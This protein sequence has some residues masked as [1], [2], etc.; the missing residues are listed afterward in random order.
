MM[1]RQKFQSLIEQEAGRLPLWLPAFLGLGVVLFFAQNAPVSYGVPL[2]LAGISAGAAW[3]L[4][5]S[6]WRWVWWLC[7]ML[8]LGFAA[9]AYRVQAVAEPM[10]SRAMN[11]VGI[12]GVI[13]EIAVQP[14]KRAKLVLEPTWIDDIA[15]PELPALVR[16]SVRSTDIPL[17]VGDVVK[18]RANLFPPGWPMFAGDYDFARYFY[19]ER[20]G[21]L[22]YVMGHV[23]LVQAAPAQADDWRAK[24]MQLRL[25]V[26]QRVRSVVT[27][28]E[29]AVTAAL[30][31]AEQSPI[32]D[33]TQEH[34]RASGLAH[35]L[36]ISGL[37]LT[38]V[39]GAAFLA[40]RLLCLLV[41]VLRRR[42]WSKKI[43]ALGAIMLS[44]FYLALA[45]FPVAAERS[46][47]MVAF[48]L[49]A[50]LFDRQVSPLR[51][52][53]FA[54][55]VIL[56]IWP[57]SIFSIS[58]ILSF[59]ATLAILALAEDIRRPVVEFL[60]MDGWWRKPLVYLAGVMATSFVAGMA[61]MPFVMHQ[62]QQINLYS[63]P[64]NMLTSPLVSF[65]I[66][67]GVMLSLLLMPL[68]F[69][70]PI[71][72]LTGQGVHYML[73]ASAWVR[74]WPHAILHALPMTTVGVVLC[75]VGGLWLCLWQTRMRWV[76]LSLVL[77]GAFSSLQQTLPDIY[78]AQDAKM[79]TVKDAS[80]GYV[81]LGGFDDHR[82][83]KDWLE[84]VGQKT[85][86]DA[87]NTPQN[88][89]HRWDCKDGGCLITLG[90][91]RVWLYRKKGEATCPEG[92]DGAILMR[93]NAPE[94]CTPK[95]FVLDE[96]TM[97]QQGGTWLN[98]EGKNWQIKDVRSTIG[99]WP[100]HNVQEQMP[101]RDTPPVAT[102]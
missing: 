8:W 47:I 27:G 44:F 5:Q 64:A 81:L 101:P 40:L 28:D 59:A 36:S 52:L 66:M 45:N 48:F 56:L 53:G 54:A 1:L 87:N 62:F 32:T 15:P 29:G 33:A 72:T 57:E 74:A 42:G 25:A 24:L 43:A 6:S 49:L 98:I 63:L 14:D 102:N 76:G 41:P 34:M 71:L 84:F 12:E 19:F 86:P 50:V 51:S 17:Q 96:K 82:A 2:G 22:G 20:M 7:A 21:A 35:V 80:G 68:G 97:A 67:P 100:W 70:A 61:T 75:V 37:H 88:D 38:I 60:G 3:S 26:G 10:L 23:H 78:V 77:L 9:S 94:N 65:W 93:Q 18:M 16:I 91:Q 69:D 13:K 89:T 58:F 31:N 46:F 90:S 55:F 79:V 4:R 92:L 73:E 11:Y 85:F 83:A 39:A 30:M 99:D 95:A